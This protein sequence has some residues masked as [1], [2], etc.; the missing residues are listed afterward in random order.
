MVSGNLGLNLFYDW[1]NFHIYMHRHG[2][3]GSGIHVILE[4]NSTAD[5]V[6][7]ENLRHDEIPFSDA[8][9]ISLAATN[10]DDVAASTYS[11]RKAF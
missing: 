9:K 8:D 7:M 5:V 6:T 2:H 10:R 3:W 1:N 4:E 11:Y